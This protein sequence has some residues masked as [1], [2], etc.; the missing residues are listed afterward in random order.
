[1]R[2]IRLNDKMAA[3]VF[4]LAKQ[5][6]LNEAVALE[7]CK[8]YELN[9]FE[10]NVVMSMYHEVMNVRYEKKIVKELKKMPAQNEYTMGS[11]SFG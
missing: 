4:A 3:V 7:L 10:E 6:S 2:Q 5:E 11:Y 9:Q 8:E 1:M